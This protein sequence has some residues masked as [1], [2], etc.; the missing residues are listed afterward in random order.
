[1][2]NGG[3]VNGF[4]PWTL[5]DV[6]GAISGPAPNNAAGQEQDGD[7]WHIDS[8]LSGTARWSVV[9]T[10][11]IIPSG[12]TVLCSAWAF[13]TGGGVRADTITIDGFQCGS[14]GTGSAN[15]WGQFGNGPL[16]VEGDSHTVVVR[17]SAI[18]SGAPNRIRLDNVQVGAFLPPPGRQFCSV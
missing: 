14:T 6:V 3:F 10:N 2:Q 1:V 17:M 12:T 18:V 4:A 7:G 16:I 15:N 13:D 9:Q 11:V 5:S 8:L